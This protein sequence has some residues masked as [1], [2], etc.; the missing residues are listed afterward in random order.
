MTD[1]EIQSIGNVFSGT[2]SHACVVVKDI[3]KTIAAYQ[4][5]LHTGER[6][7]LKQ[8]GAPEDARVTYKG[9]PTPTRAYQ[10]FFTVGGLR[11]EILQ[12]DEN[13]S[14]WKDFVD[15]NGDCFHHVAYDVQDMDAALKDLEKMGAPLIQ[16]GYYNG[17]RY[18]YVD[19][20][21]VF[22]VMLELLKAT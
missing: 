2:F 18:A 10:T 14:T 20:E 3:E 13:L 15:R 22:G 16:T 7:R 6:P 19:S 9:Q 8:T 5:L 12:P 17:G 21:D 1:Q 11:I 4:T